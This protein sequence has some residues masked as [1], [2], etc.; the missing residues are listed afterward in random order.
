MIFNGNGCSG[1]HHICYDLV[2]SVELFFN[3]MLYVF[4]DQKKKDG[5]AQGK[6]EQGHCGIGDKKLEFDR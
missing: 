5:K 6:Y 1:F 3:I 2:G 4:V